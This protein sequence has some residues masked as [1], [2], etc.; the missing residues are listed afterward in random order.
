[1]IIQYLSDLHLEFG[2]H[3][4]LD[5]IK[6][7]DSD[8]VVLAGDTDNSKNIISSIK[9]IYSELNK[10]MIVIMG[11]HEYY[12]STKQSVDLKL[13]EAFKDHRHIHVLN[14]DVWEYDGVVFVGSTGWWAQFPTKEA[15]NTMNDFKLIHDIVPANYGVDW[16]EDSYKF[17]N[18]NLKK[19]DSRL[20][21]NSGKKVVCISHNGPSSRSISKEFEGDPLNSCFVFSWGQTMMLWHKPKIWIHG[22]IHDSKDYTFD[23]TKVL[24]NPFGYDNY[25]HM[26]NIGFDPCK[27]IE[28]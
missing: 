22:H 12:H 4:I 9:W 24:C 21:K 26:L 23:D 3:H 18:L 2:S 11:N 19:H 8:I 28:I 1:M 17:F 25:D 16:G 27:I 7:C 6:Q 13:D 5:K 14:D 15:L 20:T 10:H